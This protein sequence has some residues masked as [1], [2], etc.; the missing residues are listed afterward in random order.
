[1]LRED[2]AAITD[3]AVEPRWGRR[4][5]GSRLLAACT[6]LWREDGFRTALAWAFEADKALQ[7]FLLSAGW[8]PDRVARDLDVDDMLVTQVRF[9]TDLSPQ[10]PRLDQTH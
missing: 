10:E 3:L 8:S 4:G 5:H 6:D 7:S 9:H 1:M 2:V